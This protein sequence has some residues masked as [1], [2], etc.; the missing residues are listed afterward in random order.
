MPE[1]NRVELTVQ[2]IAR[3]ALRYT[4]AGVPIIKAQARHASQ[5]WEAGA[6]RQV[7]FQVQLVAVGEVAS[8]LVDAALGEP[9]DCTGFLAARRLGGKGLELHL[10]AMQPANQRTCASSP[11]A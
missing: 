6:Q 11:A 10:V 9:Y 1:H 3:E 2:L 5:Q 8:Q 4:P 7:E